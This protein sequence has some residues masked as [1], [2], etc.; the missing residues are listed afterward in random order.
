MP[1]PVPCDIG[2]WVRKAQPCS[3]RERERESDGEV[4]HISRGAVGTRGSCLRP[5]GAS[6]WGSHCSEVS[7]RSLSGD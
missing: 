4:N 7:G 3:Q 1:S 6:Q 5:L 2:L